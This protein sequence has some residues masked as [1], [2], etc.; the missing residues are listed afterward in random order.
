MDGIEEVFDAY[1]TLDGG[2]AGSMGI[3]TWEKLCEDCGVIKGRLFTEADADAV[4]AKV[5]APRTPGG[6]VLDNV[7]ANTVKKF[8]AIAGVDDPQKFVETCKRG[9]IGAT[10]AK[11]VPKKRSIK[12][13]QGAP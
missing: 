4:F 9:P 12:Q 3:A 13:M 11:T 1:C 7:I 10:S 8:L 6:H 5:C 2:T